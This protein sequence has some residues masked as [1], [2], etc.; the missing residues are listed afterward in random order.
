MTTEKEKDGKSIGM[1]TNVRMELVLVLLT[2]VG[3]AG[4]LYAK[5]TEMESEARRAW[6]IQHE[7]LWSKEMAADNP[8]L[9]VPDPQAIVDM[10][11]Q[12][13]TPP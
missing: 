1:K 2:T 13:N 11:N 10:M 12:R 5:L 7:I 4:A 9:K 8:A 3:T 6:T